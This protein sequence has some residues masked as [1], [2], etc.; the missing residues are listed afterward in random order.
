MLEGDKKILEEK[1]RLAQKTQK[2][3]V[4]SVS[5]LRKSES[6]KNNFNDSFVTLKITPSSNNL[7][8]ENSIKHMKNELK[9]YKN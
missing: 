7:N 2:K 1:L 6:T 9:F 3:E 4:Q 8:Y 5:P